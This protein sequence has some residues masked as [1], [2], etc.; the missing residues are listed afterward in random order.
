MKAST[1]PLKI[2]LHGMDERAARMFAMFL[3][4]PARG[5]CEIVPEGRQ[6]AVVVDLDGVGADRL[7]LDVR[8]KFSGP[9]LVLSVREKVLRH[10]IWVRKPVQAS[11][12]ISAVERLRTEMNTL[13]VLH[14]AE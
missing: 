12:F 7:W 6:E 4:G 8:R 10:S 11:E 14:K 3:E 1:E 13:E 9:A 5:H 2:T